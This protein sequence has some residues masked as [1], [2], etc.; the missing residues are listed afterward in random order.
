M[1]FGKAP[2][3]DLVRATPG[4]TATCPTCKAPLRAKCGRAKK[5]LWHWAH[6]TKECDPWHEGEGQWH[7]AWKNRAPKDCIEVVIPPHRADIRTRDGLVIELQA[8][9]IDAVEIDERETFYDRMIWLL[10]GR[11]WRAARR[12]LFA[13]GRFRDCEHCP[14]RMWSPGI[15]SCT[16][17]ER[18]RVVDSTLGDRYNWNHRRTSFDGANRPVYIDTG[19]NV[20]LLDAQ[21]SRFGNARIM[22]Y[23]DFCVEFGL[24]WDSS[25]EPLDADPGEEDS[26][27]EPPP[28]RRLRRRL[29][30]RDCSNVAPEPFD[31]INLSI[32]VDGEPLAVEGTPANLE[33]T[34]RIATHL[35]SELE[36]A[37][38]ALHDAGARLIV[39]IT[40]YTI[41]WAIHVTCCTHLSQQLVSSLKTSKRELSQAKRR[42][43]KAARLRGSEGAL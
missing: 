33:S 39:S 9:A 3:G 11:T 27:P 8:S 2:S 21:P 25:D 37:S 4:E 16:K 28:P 22:S 6:L 14:T 13:K 23:R 7:L 24:S 41:G 31:G 43:H 34:V 35:R 10:D 32:T 26:V 42:A 5:Q 38:C 20:V 40:G 30:A 15:N 17:C 1:L 19:E 12:F 36:Q 29:Y 18:G